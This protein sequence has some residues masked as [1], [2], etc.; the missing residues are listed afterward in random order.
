MELIDQMITTVEIAEMMGASHKNILQKLEGS[1]RN[2]KHSD[3]II[4]ILS[5]L[6]FQ[7]A[8]FFIKSSYTDEQG[9]ERPCYNCT[10]MGCEF[11]AHKFQ[12][13][14]GI[15]FTARYIER[16]HQMEDMIKNQAAPKDR[17]APKQENWFLRNNQKIKAICELFGISRREFHCRLL[18]HL[19]QTYDL[20]KAREELEEQGIKQE[21]AIEVIYYYPQIFA[22]SEKYIN[23]FFE[24]VTAKMG[25]M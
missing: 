17:E 25:N 24:A 2:G 11:L 21:H 7:P 23:Y 12:G 9:K 1:E 5:R 3:G 14:R 22:D 15:E 20:N 18:R 8:K 4:E 19:E 16:F 10:R 6:N 13:E